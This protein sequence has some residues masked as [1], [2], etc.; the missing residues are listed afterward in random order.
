MSYFGN[1]PVK[2]NFSA[3]KSNSSLDACAAIF[4]VSAQM[5]VSKMLHFYV[6][7]ILALRTTVAERI[8]AK[9]FHEEYCVEL[10]SEERELLKKPTYKTYSGHEIA[11]KNMTDGW[12]PS[13]RLEYLEQC[14]KTTRS[15]QIVPKYTQ[16]GF[17]KM[18][19]PKKLFEFMLNRRVE[20]FQEIENCGVMRNCLTVQDNFLVFANNSA[21]MGVKNVENVENVVA[22]TM[23]PILENWA[24]VSLSDEAIVYGIRRY[25]RGAKLWEH[26]D[27]VPTHILS[28]ILQVNAYKKVARQERCT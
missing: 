11:W 6:L 24:G 8:C 23:K 17:I 13:R 27:R 12:T 28:A 5:N 18:A 15:R 1:F 9:D 22:K 10:S 26:T 4:L 20:S 21:V 7:F 2:C 25:T 3:S 16:K 19:I 14:R